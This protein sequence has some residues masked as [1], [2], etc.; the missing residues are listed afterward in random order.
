[1]KNDKNN[2]KNVKMQYFGLALFPHLKMNMSKKS[3]I[4][5]V[6]NSCTKSVENRL[7]NTIITLETN[8]MQDLCWVGTET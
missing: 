8:L 3:K 6:R 1:M 7:W 2:A 4:A 5:K